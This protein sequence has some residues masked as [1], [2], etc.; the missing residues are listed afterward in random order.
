MGGIAVRLHALPRPTFDVD[1]TAA[2]AR[3]ALPDV[4]RAAE[5]IG[6]T[7]PAAQASGWIDTVRGLPV[8]KFQW[9]VGSRAIDVDV[10]LSETPFQNQLLKRRQRIVVEG[11]FVTAEDLIVLKLLASRPKDRVDVSDI[12]FVQGT[13][14]EAYLRRW[15]AMLGIAV[16][17]EDALTVNRD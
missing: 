13:L 17:L 12:L 5:E 2:I 14:D 9:F 8:V 15:A 3:D 7:I 1:F 10:F 11:W 4:Y 6:F 16:E